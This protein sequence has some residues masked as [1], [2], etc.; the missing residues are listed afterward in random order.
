[1]PVTHISEWAERHGVAL[2]RLYA[3]EHREGGTMALGEGIPA[4]SRNDL[5]VFSAGEWEK[6]KH[7]LIYES[8]LDRARSQLQH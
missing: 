3:T 4:P 2:D 8:W 5:S 1:M 7:L 6:H